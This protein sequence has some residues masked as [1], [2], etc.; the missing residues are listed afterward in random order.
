MFD[1]KNR[2]RK[3][4]KKAFECG[5][6]DAWRRFALAYNQQVGSQEV[7]EMLPLTWP[8]LSETGANGHPS[9]EGDRR[10][11]DK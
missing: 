7:P 11:E 6:H 5:D 3:K 4:L 2:L 9:K 8:F 1:S 10:F